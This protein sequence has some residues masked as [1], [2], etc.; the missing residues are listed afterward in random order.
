MPKDSAESKHEAPGT[1]VTVSL[2]ALT[3][4]L[5]QV[6]RCVDS[7]EKDRNLRINLIFGG[8]W[9]HAEHTVLGLEPDSSAWGNVVGSQSRDTYRHQ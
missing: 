8:I 9:A 6:S 1:M 2:P 5:D 7:G 3:T 4:S